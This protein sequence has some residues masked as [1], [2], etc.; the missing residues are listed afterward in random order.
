MI[1][2]GFAMGIA[3]FFFHRSVMEGRGPVFAEIAQT[4]RRFGGGWGSYAVEF[5]ILVGALWFARAGQSMILFFYGAYTALNI[6]SYMML[7]RM[8]RD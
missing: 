3:N 2:A 8:N 5:V 7:S 1:W 4:L 6:G